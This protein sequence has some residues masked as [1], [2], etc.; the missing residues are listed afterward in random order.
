MPLVLCILRNRDEYQFIAQ[1]AGGRSAGKGNKIVLHSNNPP[2]ASI[3][4]RHTQGHKICPTFPPYCNKQNNTGMIRSTKNSVAQVSCA[5]VKIRG[6]T[7][8]HKSST[9]SQS[10]DATLLSSAPFI[11]YIATHTITGSCPRTSELMA[12]SAFPL[13]SVFEVFCGRHPPRPPHPPV[14]G[15]PICQRGARAVPPTFL[16][17]DPSERSPLANLVPRQDG[18]VQNLYSSTSQGER[19][20]S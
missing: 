11:W 18:E 19:F 8:C 7:T 1:L 17:V 5:R 13:F 20:Q 4:L 10:M 12:P 16:L 14:R 15:R 2:A 9:S 6:S 3:A